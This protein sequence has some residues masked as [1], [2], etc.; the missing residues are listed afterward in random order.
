MT[1]S[2]FWPL[3]K[4]LLALLFTFAFI[5]VNA[6]MMIYAE[7]KI[8]GHIQRR[9]GPLH[10]GPH[11]LLQCIADVLKLLCKQ[12]FSPPLGDQ[13][14]YWLA[15]FVVFVPTVICFL[16][17]PFD[18]HLRA[19]DINLGL[20]LILAF[21]GLNV[22]S[23]CFA[24]WGSNNK[25]SLLGAA[26]SVSQSISY[27][28]PLLLSVLAAVIMS[29]S[30]NLNEITKSQGIWPWEWFIVYNPL[31]FLIYF[32]CAVAETNRAPFDLPEAESEL[33]GGFHT[34][35]SGMGF[36][37][38][39]LAEYA[40]M[41]IVAAVAVSL[42]LGGWQGP[43]ASGWWWFLAKMYV[44]VFVIMWFRWT[45]PRVRFDQL[46][47]FCWKV[48]IPISLANLIIS[49]FISRWIG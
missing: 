9:P 43:I 41:L 42:F 12:I 34:E 22:V 46:L 11:G 39:F 45:F 15:P 30:T 31:V 27:E 36:G 17:I 5:V 35:Y 7:R 44:I 49:L 21:S 37:L 29:G 6:V 32:I 23:L 48:L 13:L 20:L 4:I 38:F 8:A 16:A 24:G 33:T 26:R 28:I 25:F 18:P 10:V 1:L 2:Y 40:N 3:I 14:L 47:N 19:L